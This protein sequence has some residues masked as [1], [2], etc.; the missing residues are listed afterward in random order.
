MMSYHSWDILSV[1]SS[2]LLGHTKIMQ[3]IWKQNIEKK[4][5]QSLNTLE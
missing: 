1:T 3:V 2:P 4:Y 5:V